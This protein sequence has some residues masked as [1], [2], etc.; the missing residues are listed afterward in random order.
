LGPVRPVLVDSHP[1][2]ASPG[3]STR[4]RWWSSALDPMMAWADVSSERSLGRSKHDAASSHPTTHSTCV[5]SSFLH[6][7]HTKN[8]F[9]LSRSSNAST[10]VESSFL[11]CC[12][13]KNSFLLSR[14][15]NASGLYL[16]IPVPLTLAQNQPVLRT[17][18]KV[19]PLLAHTKSH[20][21]C[22]ASCHYMRVSFRRTHVFLVTSGG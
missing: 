16:E 20:S 5:E 9:L 12:H 2:R 6:C 22:L 14:S 17:G 19:V 21:I 7:C 10:C 11:H 8:S 13:T 15:S 3:T 1:T 18:P 4:A